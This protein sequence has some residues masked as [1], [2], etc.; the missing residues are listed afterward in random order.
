M[1]RA[2]ATLLAALTAGTGA[3]AAP[4]TDYALQCRGCHGAEGAGVPGRVPGLAGMAALLE[5]PAGRAR[6]LAV[7]GVRQASLSDERLA[8]LLV[9]AADRFAPERAE[10]AAPL[11][12]AEVRR[13]R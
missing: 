12:A 8:A 6:L 10:P 11:D 4:E 9:W 7:P 2:L 13:L 1:T 3:G 5:T